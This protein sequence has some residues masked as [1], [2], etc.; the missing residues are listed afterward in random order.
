MGPKNFII[1][2]IIVV[3]IIIS[4]SSSYSSSRVRPDKNFQRQSLSLVPSY[5]IWYL[6]L[7]LLHI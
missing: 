5:F 2:I 3:V 7:T 6:L 1:I 4:S